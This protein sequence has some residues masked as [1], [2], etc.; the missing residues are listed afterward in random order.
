[1][2]IRSAL[3]R[4]CKL[5]MFVRRKGV[6]RI[7]CSGDPRHKQRQGFHT[8][9]SAIRPSAEQIAMEQQQLQRERVV[10]SMLVSLRLFSYQ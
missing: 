10:N 2:K 8:I 5:C 6:L 9:S 7:V 4:M 3:K 1:M